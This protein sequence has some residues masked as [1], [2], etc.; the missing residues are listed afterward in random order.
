MTNV[1]ILGFGV[2]GGGVAELLKNNKQQVEKL[3]G[4]EINI[5]Y[6]LDLR[7]FPDSPF[8]DK[9]THDFDQIL[10][11]EEVDCVIE[12]MGGS[13]PAYEYTMAALKAGKSVITSNKEVVA[14]YGDEFLRAAEENGVCYRFEAAVGGGIPVISPM[15]SLIG[16]NKVSE[17]RGILNGT[18][19]YILTKMFSEGDTFEDS[20][21]DAQNKGYAERNPDADV[22]GVDACRKIAIL[23]SL[24]TGILPET[25]AIHTEGI[26]AI[27]KNDVTAA[28]S[29][30]L[31]IKLLGRCIIS[32]EGMHI[33]VAPF[34]LGDN[35]PLSGV[36]GVYNA[37]EIIGDP[38]GNLMFYGQ[39]AGAGATASAVV[40]DL[41]QIMCSGR[42]TAQP[43]MV[44]SADI[45]PF[46][47]FK[48]RHYLSVC[49][50]RSR[51]EQLFGSVDFIGEAED[52]AFVTEEIS[53]KELT[54]KIK[55]LN[56]KSHI[57]L[58]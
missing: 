45:L 17:V 28:E 48:C 4:D 21:R 55:N 41:M 20:L 37:I 56:V 54:E 33:M 19:N 15:I 10:S 25:D 46:C 47:D 42:N 9:I 31:S 5:K 32:E 38:I 34:M 50:E 14:R 11:D 2:V 6:I 1:A 22:L 13:H 39:G 36:H 52:I 18:T 7:D 40:G 29:L 43:K 58:L 44:K 24:V 8:A 35:S 26:T 16:Q 3:G 30:G 53:E 23:T 51:V 49:A 57:R 27:D 12:V